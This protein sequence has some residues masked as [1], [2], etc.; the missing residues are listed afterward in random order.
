MKYSRFLCI[1]L[2]L[3]LLVS[4]SPIRAHAVSTGT[5]VTV[6]AGVA[7]AGILVGLG[8][9]PDSAQP[10]V[11]SNLV[12][13]VTQSL[14]DLG[15]I[16]ADMLITVLNPRDGIYYIQRDII[17]TVFD[18]CVSTGAVSSGFSSNYSA[19]DVL[20]FSTPSSSFSISFNQDASVFLFRRD[21]VSSYTP[22][23]V[24][25]LA[26]SSSDT[27]ASSSPNWR[28]ADQNQILLD[29]GYHYYCC[30][31]YNCY[32]LSGFASLPL[33]TDSYSII[34][35]NLASGQYPSFSLSDGLVAGDV[36]AAPGSAVSD[37]YPD[38]RNSEIS[39]DDPDGNVNVPWWV[40]S[41]PASIAAADALTQTD[42]WQGLGSFIEEVPATLDSILSALFSFW[43]DVVSLGQD[44]YN[45]LLNI[46]ELLRSWAATAVDFFSRSWVAFKDAAISFWGSITSTLSDIL[47]WIKALPSAIAEAISNLLSSLFVPDV[48]EI[49]AAVDVMK[50]KFP[51]FDSIIGTW[52]SFQL[53]L[54]GS[55]PV[56]YAH[57][58]NA[59]G[60]YS[61]GG[62][63]AVLD[64]SFY[65]RYK[66]L[67]DA[68]LS[69]ALWCFFG[70]R[71][72]V[73][74]PGIISGVPGDIQTSAYV[75]D[76][77]RGSRKK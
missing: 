36:V 7:V 1:V 18:V 4:I 42:V 68:V 28:F 27:I 47:E 33:I 77:E 24:L 29:D 58:Q 62:T 41:V 21:N 48:A 60:N 65:E 31:Y 75:D 34:A 67:G 54:S 6:G 76:I 32:D 35:K 13:T 40:L 52:K 17:Q 19:G 53:R 14:K 8:L 30:Y 51:F 70:W 66:P 38:W 11:F 23:Y 39:S 45:G 71:I 46:L 55:P 59:E 3:I 12:D 16:G 72:F 15:K 44:L 57:L 26:S 10:E 63:V 2:C 61:W 69:A 22:I 73:K 64:M 49:T 56:I 25:A 9:M 5:A 37:A 50:L 43:G 20:S 74:L